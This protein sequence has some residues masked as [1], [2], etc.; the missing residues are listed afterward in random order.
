MSD[1]SKTLRTA[2]ARFRVMSSP[3]PL[4]PAAVSVPTARPAGLGLVRPSPAPAFLIVLV[5]PDREHRP[6]LRRALERAAGLTIAA[7]CGSSA[8]GLAAIRT[9]KPD[10][11]FLE[12]GLPDGSGFDLLA[13]LAPAERPAAVFVTAQERDAARAFEADAAD[14]V[15]RP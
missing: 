13:A 4:T 1:S 12:V 11:V 2:P 6:H 14:C 10:A 5:D 3:K 7:E 15:V 8:E 9:H